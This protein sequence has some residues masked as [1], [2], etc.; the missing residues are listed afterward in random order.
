MLSPAV[1]LNIYCVLQSLPGLVKKI[2][3]PH[4]LS[5]YPSYSEVFDTIN[6]DGPGIHIFHQ[7]PGEAGVVGRESLPKNY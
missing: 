4:F 6:L 3:D 1:L 2:L 5:F 7:L